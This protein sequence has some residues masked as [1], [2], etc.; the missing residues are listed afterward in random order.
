MT[1]PNPYNRVYNFSNYQAVNPDDPLPANQIDAEFNALK[2]VLDQVRVSIA[3]LQRDDFALKNATVGYD[4][5]KAELNGFGF[6]PPAAW[7]P[8]TAYI[9]RD[10]VFAAAAFYQC[11][12][13]HTSTADF[14]DDLA[15]EFWELIADFTSIVNQ[16]NASNLTTGTLPD[17]R[18]SFTVSTFIR[19]LLDDTSAANARVTLGATSSADV[20]AAI[21]A[22]LATY[23]SAGGTDVAI[24]DGGTGASNAAAAFANLKQDATSSATGVVEL[25]TDAE[26]QTGTDTTR[27]LTPANLQAVTA[28][29]TRKGVVEL[30]TTA[31]A[32]AG[33]DTARAVTPAGVAAAL[34]GLSIDYGAGNAALAYGA[35]G[36]YVFAY[37]NNATDLAAGSTYAGSTLTPSAMMGLSAGVGS[38]QPYT[39]GSA[40]SGTWMAMG[41]ATDAHHVTLFLRTV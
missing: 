41:A 22:A 12:V 26:A 24:A 13:S 36:T 10:T 6:N 39:A 16:T 27:A 8:S 30:A 7:E 2:V 34:A 11:L 19:D 20:S 1:Q 4:Q 35:V 28:T 38:Q 5:L 32:A 14:E 25:A 31:E 21:T 3:A 17:A 15:D 33:S 23:Y 29:E 37:R 18:L 40:L 9:A